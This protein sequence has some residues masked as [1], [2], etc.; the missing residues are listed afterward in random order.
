VLRETTQRF[1]FFASV[2][3]SCFHDRLNK[4]T[5]LVG[6]YCLGSNHIN[7]RGLAKTSI[8]AKYGFCYLDRV[9]YSTSKQN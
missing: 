7:Q 4:K 2:A 8:N 5:P 3:D 1:F 9:K 6:S